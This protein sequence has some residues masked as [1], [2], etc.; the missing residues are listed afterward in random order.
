MLPRGKSIC[1]TLKEVRQR[2]ADANGISYT[3]RKCHHKGD[4]KGTCP[5]CEEE[6]SYLENTLHHLQAKGIAIKVA[7]IAAGLITTCLPATA[8]F[9]IEQRQTKPEVKDNKIIIEGVAYDENNEILIGAEI[10]YSK[11][12]KTRADMDG[13][14]TLA[15]P[16]DAILTISYVGCDTISLPVSEIANPSN[17]IVRLKYNHELD[18]RIVIGGGMGNLALY[19]DDVYGHYSI[20]YNKKKK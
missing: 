2:I 4:C 14:F 5:A 18:E 8:H 15:V 3:P 12:K 6:R 9:P 10:S 1:K 16:K 20:N 11:K 19:S 7:G 17:L 13:K